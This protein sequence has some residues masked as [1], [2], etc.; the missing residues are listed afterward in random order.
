MFAVVK[1]SAKSPS[2][3]NSG[4]TAAKENFDSMALTAIHA[5][6]IS[7]SSVA[8]L[9][10]TA[11]NAETAAKNAQAKNIDV[12]IPVG[13]YAPGENTSGTAHSIN[14]TDSLYKRPSPRL[15]IITS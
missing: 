12:F 1:N 9:N 11:L 6:Y 5:I 7:E 15:R 8:G 4:I 14:R 10:P 13:I 2:A 3:V